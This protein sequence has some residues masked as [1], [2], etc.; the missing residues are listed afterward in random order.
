MTP[1]VRRKQSPDHLHVSRFHCDLK[2]LFA[3]GPFYRSQD[4]ALFGHA[5]EMLARLFIEALLID[6][7]LAD[8]VW[9]LWNDGLI[10]DELAMMAWLHIVARLGTCERSS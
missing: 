2:T 4:A 10:S 3:H 1:T 8:R 6:K 9:T 5:R 7:H